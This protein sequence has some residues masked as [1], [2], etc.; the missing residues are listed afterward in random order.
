MKFS[1]L[2]HKQREQQLTLTRQ[3]F[4]LFTRR[5]ELLVLLPHQYSLYGQASQ[6][7]GDFALLLLFIRTFINKIGRRLSVMSW[8]EFATLPA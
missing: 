7:N 4:K 2:F 6:Y 3:D 8:E 5:D 1:P